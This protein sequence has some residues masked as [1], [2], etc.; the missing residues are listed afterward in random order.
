MIFGLCLPRRLI[1]A[2]CSRPRFQ[3]SISKLTLIF[4]CRGFWMGD[5]DLDF[6]NR[7]PLP[8]TASPKAKRSRN[9]L[10]GAQKKDGPPPPLLTGGS[11]HYA[12]ERCRRPTV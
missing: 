5:P 3:R 2:S 11:L 12:A 4:R 8:T 6:S 10:A 9:G 1:F 7:L